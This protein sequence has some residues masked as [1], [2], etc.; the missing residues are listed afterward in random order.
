MA[1]ADVIWEKLQ[2]Q[3]RLLMDF[4][5]ESDRIKRQ[6]EA[7]HQDLH[8]RWQLFHQLISQEN[9][10]M[11]MLLSRYGASHEDA[12]DFFRLSDSLVEEADFVYRQKQDQLYIEEEEFERQFYRKR[13]DLEEELYQI[14]R[15]YAD[16]DE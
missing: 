3:E 9:D 2:K 12:S 1:N 8:D 11:T 16:A 7:K 14:R 4:E 6:F 5:E 10:Q 15:D 13:D